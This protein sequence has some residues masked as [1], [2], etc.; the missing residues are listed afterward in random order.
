[1][2]SASAPFA[3][4]LQAC[5]GMPPTPAMFQARA[6][7]ERLQLIHAMAP[8][9]PD[10]WMV[11]AGHDDLPGTGL[12]WQSSAKGSSPLPLTGTSVM[13]PEANPPAQ[14][15]LGNF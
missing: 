4:L 7:R 8:D 5:H 15:F 6:V 2:L 10:E 14:F 11:L 12:T 3:L 13:R 1:M 9:V